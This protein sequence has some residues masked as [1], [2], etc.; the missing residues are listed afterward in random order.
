MPQN[1]GAHFTGQMA[2]AS[3]LRNSMKRLATIGAT[4]IPKL[5][6]VNMASKTEVGGSKCELKKF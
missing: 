6:L 5:L 4:G 2:I 3:C 1:F